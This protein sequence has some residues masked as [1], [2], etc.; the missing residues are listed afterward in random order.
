MSNKSAEFLYE[1]DG[2]YFYRNAR[3][4]VFSTRKQL[5]SS[6]TEEEGEDKVT[7]IAKVVANK[8]GKAAGEA[9]KTDAE[10]AKLVD[11]FS[12]AMASDKNSRAPAVHVAE[13][14]KEALTNLSDKEV[15]PDDIDME[16]QKLSMK[17]EQA[18]IIFQVA[19]NS[20]LQKK[21]LANSE[22]KLLT[23]FEVGTQRQVRRLQEAT[24]D[25]N[26]DA[27]ENAGLRKG[28]PMWLIRIAKV[29]SGFWGIIIVI[30]SFFTV[31]PIVMLSKSLGVQIKNSPLKWILTMAL[32]L[33]LAFGVYLLIAVNVGLWPFV[34]VPEGAINALLI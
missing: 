17:L 23:E 30:L 8:G 24:Y 7:A 13:A 3:G 19:N 21:V 9:R 11:G 29:T 18:G 2:L 6:E 32:Y 27:L 14:F 10:L 20:S 15:T 28:S 12:M 33:G 4:K 1:E 22:Q 16:T 31:T 25:A 5:H 26:Q 34:P